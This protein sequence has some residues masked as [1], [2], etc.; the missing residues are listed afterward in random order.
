MK[1]LWKVIAD[2]PD[3]AVSNQGRVKRLTPA[4]NTYVGKILKPRLKKG[5]QLVKLNRAMRLVHRLV[6]EAFIPNPLGLPEVN[7]KNG[8]QKWNNRVSN[9]EWVTHSDNMKHAFATGLKQPA[10]GSKHGSAI[11]NTKQVK[12]IRNLLAAGHRSQSIADAY[13][14]SPQTVDHIKAGRSWRHA[15]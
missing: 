3:Y 1:E 15:V 9:L 13:N 14:V 11:L 12:Q 2:H 6:V 8:K 7:H 10:K 4:K 5:Y